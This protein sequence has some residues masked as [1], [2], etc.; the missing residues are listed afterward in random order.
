MY[1]TSAQLFKQ[2]AS[3]PGVHSVVHLTTELLKRYILVIL[4]II[5]YFFVPDVKHL[6]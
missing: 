1:L 4:E 2:D 5:I 6:W 3:T